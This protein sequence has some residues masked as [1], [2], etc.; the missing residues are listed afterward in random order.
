MN[1][2]LNIGIVPC[3]HRRARL[4]VRVQ[5]EKGNLSITG[6]I[7]PLRSGNALGN[8][9]QI[10]WDFK[11]PLHNIDLLTT[12]EQMNFTKGWDAAMWL[13]LLRIWHNW[14]LN[15]MQAGCEHQVGPEWDIDKMLRVND[16]RQERAG[17]VRNTEHPAGLLTKTCPVCGYKY[18]TKWLKRRLPKSVVKFLEG[19]PETKVAPAW[20]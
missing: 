14:N 16:G 4:F 2:I 8:C 6:V 1:K 3:G 7:G 5:I 17:W 18:G 15:N 11:H 9:G 10:N 19:L 13:E 12:P 20:C